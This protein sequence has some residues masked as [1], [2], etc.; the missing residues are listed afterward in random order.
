MCQILL[1]EKTCWYINLFKYFLYRYCFEPKYWCSNMYACEES[2]PPH[3]LSYFELS[4]FLSLNFFLYNRSWKKIDWSLL[5]KKQYP[6]WEFTFMNELSLVVVVSP[7]GIRFPS[8]RFQLP[9]EWLST[10]DLLFLY[11]GFLLTYVVV[12]HLIHSID[13]FL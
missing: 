1:C 13:C 5:F 3:K 9:F 2:P 11:L 10:R 7:L 12:D 6:N 4:K 8:V